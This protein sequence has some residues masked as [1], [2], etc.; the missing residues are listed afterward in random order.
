MQSTY[1]NNKLVI[2][3]NLKM[4]CKII[5]FL[6]LAPL[7]IVISFPIKLDT[8]QLTSQELKILEYISN[9][10][11]R[12]TFLSHFQTPECNCESLTCVCCLKFILANDER[13]ICLDAGFDE[14]DMKANVQ[15][16]FD[17]EEIL[18]YSLRVT[19]VCVNL[20]IPLSKV[21]ICIDAYKVDV[22]DMPSS[23]M[24]CMKAE[25]SLFIPFLNVDFNCVKWEH[26]QLTLLS[27]DNAEEITATVNVNLNSDRLELTYNPPISTKLVQQ[28]KDL[29]QRVAV[30]VAAKDKRYASLLK[31]KPNIWQQS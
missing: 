5:F 19:N 15:L 27:N 21:K 2:K 20:P 7:A 8:S 6:C 13:E 4:W 14:N 23:G 24:F 22:K 18:T 26:E 29:S 17:R 31:E 3:N 25:L 10:T 1:G 11:N 30:T 16:T 12:K 28:I 9:N